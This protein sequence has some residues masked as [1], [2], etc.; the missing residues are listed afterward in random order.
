MSFLTASSVSFVPSRFLKNQLLAVALGAFSIV[1]ILIIWPKLGSWLLTANFLPH[2]YCY[3]RNPALVWTN[4]IADSLIAVS[5][6]AISVT[7]GHLGYK[8]R[9]DI[10]YHWMFLAFGLFILG[11]G[12]THLVEGVTVWIPVYVLAAAVKLFTAAVSLTTAAVLPFTVPHVFELIQQAKATE[13]RTTELRASEE[14]KDALLQEVHHRVKN[15]LAVICSL[16]YLES[17][18]S[19]HE[20]TAETFRDMQNRV[21]SMAL[22]HESLYGAENLARIDF[23]EYARNLAE[24]ILASHGSPI[25]P[26]HLKTELEPVTMGA[27]LAVPCGLILNELVSNAFKHGFPKGTGGEIKLIL[28]SEA[29]GKYTLCVQDTGVGIP[30]GLDFKTSPSLGLKLVRL[31]TQQ[32]RGSFELVRSDPGTVAHLQFEVNQNAC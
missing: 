14:R 19:T 16:F 3:L 15:N 11:C 8:G 29:G 4:V 32:I 5:Y 2:A 26:I 24:D 23:A 31:L 17:I 9:R 10:P 22:V 18:H 25:V 27:D 7:L 6:F 12:G 30:A 21:H 1:T 20:E 28:H 13:Q